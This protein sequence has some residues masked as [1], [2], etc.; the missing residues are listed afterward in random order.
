MIRTGAVTEIPRRFCL[1]RGPIL[2]CVE[3]G[4]MTA[5]RWCTHHGQSRAHDGWKRGGSQSLPRLGSD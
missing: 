1:Y 2:R 4:G 5:G 3:G